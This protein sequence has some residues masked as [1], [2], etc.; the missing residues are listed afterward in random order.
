MG[1]IPKKI[2]ERPWPVQTAMG[3]SEM[4]LTSKFVESGIGTFDPRR[5]L[6][7]DRGLDVPAPDGFVYV[8][9]HDANANDLAVGRAMFGIDGVSAWCDFLVVDAAYR[10]YRLGEQMIR[11]VNHLGWSVHGQS[12]QD[13]LP[14]AFW[15]SPIG[16]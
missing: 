12:N 4:R 8:T 5:E 16:S 10:G 7:D 14:E 3:S 2:S 1:L 9:V 11:Y 6:W 13:N 15:S